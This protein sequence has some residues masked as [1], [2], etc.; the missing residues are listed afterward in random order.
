M[1]ANIGEPAISVI[2]TTYNPRR[3]LLRWTL[4]SFQRQ[5]LKRD[6]WELI[7]VDNNSSPAVDEQEWSDIAGLPLHVI[8]EP[9]QGQIFA[10][11]CG[12]QQARGDLLV[13]A[14]DDNYLGADYLQRALDI[15]RRHP[16][17]GTFGGIAEG[18]F[19][20]RARI[21]QSALFP[22]L[23]VRNHGESPITSSSLEWGP[24][25]PIGAG[26]VVRRAA[27]EFFFDTMS[28]GGEDR[29]LGRKPKEL[30]SGDD[31]LI[32]KSSVRGGY[33]NSYQPALRLQH[34]IKSG[35]LKP[36]YLR[37]L[38]EGYGHSHVKMQA[39]LGQPEG[40]VPERVVC[41]K[42]KKA[43]RK[44]LARDGRSGAVRWYWSVGYF[45]ELCGFG[46]DEALMVLQ[47]ARATL[48][49]ARI[50][51]V[52]GSAPFESKPLV[53]HAAR[54]R[55][56]GLVSQ[57]ARLLPVPD[58]GEPVVQ[59]GTSLGEA[60]ALLR[61]AAA[62]AGIHPAKTIIPWHGADG[63][64]TF[65]D[66]RQ[67]LFHLA[68]APRSE[69]ACDLRKPQRALFV[70]E[71]NPLTEEL[72]VDVLHNEAVVSSHVFG[73]KPG[74]NVMVVPLELESGKN[75][76]ALVFKGASVDA[77]R[78]AL[79]VS[80]LEIIADDATKWPAKPVRKRTKQKRV[81]PSC[82]V[83]FPVATPATSTNLHRISMVVPC[84]NAAETLERT[85]TSLLS[86]DYDNL[87]IILMDGG[88][89]DGTAQIIDR[90][91]ERLAFVR[92]AD[93]SGQVD[94]INRG[95]RQATGEIRGWLCA[96][97]ELLPGCLHAVNGV[98]RAHPNADV[99][100]GGCERVYA[101]NTH[102]VT[103]PPPD[104]WSMIALRNPLEQ[105]ST[106]WRTKLHR[107]AGD[108]DADFQLV[109][110][111]EFWARFAMAGARL[112]TTS[113]PL[114]RYHF[115]SDNKTSRAGNLHAVEGLRL[116]RTYSP[117][118]GLAADCYQILYH[119]DLRGC[120]DRNPSCL[121]GLI[122]RFRKVRALLANLAGRQSIDLYN[123][124]FASLQERGLV[125]WQ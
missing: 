89:T 57:A 122:D 110:D 73:R 72:P 86:Q 63:L 67:P 27:L 17:I 29:K 37:R 46:Q 125:W 98:F 74:G 33:A 94:A 81:P 32:A 56:A 6:A 44:R 20:Q 18:V 84:F 10:R 3:D 85:L 50:G 91:R 35:R 124:H 87:E 66:G 2:I 48:R 78:P 54:R 68:I 51:G 21:W 30:L 19:E 76:L 61:Q 116:V 108:L 99:L 106:F 112:L 11:V 120:L 80:R 64:R 40:R 105:P 71:G 47:D 90:Y 52:R 34:F 28:C 109:F 92:Q 23:A 8:R 75:R 93:D 95:F 53:P 1:I 22:Y 36:S 121:P 117:L 97:D 38:I 123:L 14:D 70:I 5:S 101:D 16:E 4:E 59:G 58:P 25:E 55:A 43:L 118:D 119:F 13:F 113:R 88:S 60:H 31:S 107:R 104:A 77:G 82:D 111:W 114:S 39:I 24:W 79:F 69:L 26:L 83:V 45:A 100:S 7:L 115:S 9:Q 96:D 41:A 62:V 102:E 15:A 103:A 12:M 49:R 65:Q 42:L